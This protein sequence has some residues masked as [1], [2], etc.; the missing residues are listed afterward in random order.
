L[1]ARFASIEIPALELQMQG[2]RPRTPAA[3]G[4]TSAA[5]PG[6]G[7]PPKDTGP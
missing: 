1:I 3:S 4:G 7:S 5:I 6:G 2:L